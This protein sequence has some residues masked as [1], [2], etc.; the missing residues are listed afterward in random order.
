MSSR[1]E[2]VFCTGLVFCHWEDAIDIEEDGM[3]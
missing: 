2:M 1:P 3:A